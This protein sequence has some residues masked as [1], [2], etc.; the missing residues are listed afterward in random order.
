MIQF[1][2]HWLRSIA[3]RTDSKSTY[4]TTQNLTMHAT[5]H[6]SSDINLITILFIIRHT[7]EGAENDTGI[8]KSNIFDSTKQ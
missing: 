3:V 1:T 4:I 5:V 6:A 2:S 8:R 7:K